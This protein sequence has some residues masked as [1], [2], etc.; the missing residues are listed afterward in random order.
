MR[1]IITGA[2]LLALAGCGGGSS[3]SSGEAERRARQAPPDINIVTPDAKAEIRSGAAALA[4]LPAGIPAY[5]GADTTASVQ[6]SGT[7]PESQGGI[8][9]FRTNDPPAQVVDFYAAAAERAGY[10]IAQ[11]SSFGATAMLTAQRAEGEVLNVT[12]TT[13]AGA[14]TQVQIIAGAPTR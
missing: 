9:G 1:A 10:R 6:V 2:A 12:A 5:P 7:A 14:G 8:H 13:A 4:G 11:R 3:E